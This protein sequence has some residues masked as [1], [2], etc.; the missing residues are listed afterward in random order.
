[1]ITKELPSF[2][3]DKDLK[4]IFFGGKGGVGKT[5]CA[6]AVALLTAKQA[7]KT[8]LVSINPAHS[9]SD[10]FECTIGG[11]ITKLNENLWGLEVNTEELVREYKKKNELYIK[12][13]V[14]RGTYLDTQ[15]LERFFELSIPGM[16]ELMAV[17][18]LIDFMK[19]ENTY[20]VFI[21][22]TAATGHLMRFF[23]LPKLLEDFAEILGIMQAKH[24]YI[25]STFARKK[26]PKDEMDWFLEQQIRDV[27]NIR[28]FFSDPRKTEFVPVTIP[29]SMGVEETKLLLETIEKNKINVKNI[30]V[31]LVNQSTECDFCRSRAEKQKKYIEQ[32]KNLF[33]NHNILESPLLPYE[34]K[35]LSNLEKFGEVLS[36]KSYKYELIKR[37]GPEQISPTP[38]PKI[39][40]DGTRKLYLFGGKG[41]LGKTTVAAATALQLAK[42]LPDKKILIFST[43]PAQA[44][45][46]SFDLLIGTE[47]LQIKENLYAVAMD[48]DEALN[49]FKQT[50]KKEIDEIFEGF[51]TGGAGIDLPFDRKMFDRTLEL[52]PPGLDELMALTKIMDFI[53]EGRYDIFILDT[54]PSG[55]LLKLLELPAIVMDWLSA[56]IKTMMKYRKI[57]SLYNCMKLVLTKKKLVKNLISLLKDESR[58]EFVVVTVPEKLGIVETERVV[59]RLRELEIPVHKIVINKVTPLSSCSFCASRA[60]RELDYVKDIYNKFSNFTIT[61]MPLFPHEVRSVDG[62]LEFAQVMYG[63]GLYD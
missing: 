7:R 48:A 51:I 37:Y 18:K 58:T 50:Y 14:D 33:P 31:N 35:G 34:V 53:E 16:D 1:M 44:L 8:L 15:D 63:A 5:T 49:E 26:L 46:R 62:L 10:I 27:K 13:I 45:G 59:K 56:L 57:V 54:A 61:E 42:M 21:I 52:S 23:S 19:E 9:L 32:L 55:H 20:D 22:D 12:T 36:G 41:G 24:R 3:C 40:F 29:E 43:D 4:L 17:R 6:A 25:R 47:P 39:K 38:G 30:I 11:S 28:A 60:E 2:L